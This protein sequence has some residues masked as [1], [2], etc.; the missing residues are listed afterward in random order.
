[1]ES[2]A[3]THELGVCSW[4]RMIDDPLECA[5]TVTDS[6]GLRVVQLALD[7]LVDHPETSGRW[8]RAFR[9]RGFTIASGM[10]APAGEDYT[11]IGSIRR[12]GGFRVEALWNGH[13]ERAKQLAELAHNAAIP[14][15]TMHAGSFVDD[16]GELCCEIVDRIRTIALVFR[17]ADIEV[18][19]ET[20]HEPAHAVL[21]LLDAL[22]VEGVGVNF[23]PANM[24]LYGSGDPIEALSELLPYVY[25]CHIKD[26]IP[27]ERRELWGTEVVVGTGRVDWLRFFGC[28]RRSQRPI[29]LMVE[30]EAGDQR[31]DDIRSAIRFVHT[32]VPERAR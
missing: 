13:L 22:A 26:A 8:L 27:S 2:I 3:H 16:K 4:S 31:V 5:A 21:A 11:S 20:G 15:V 7:P 28:L 30:R 19:F 6:L 14:L 17:D 32:H 1:M 23:D 29:G 12:T 10:M 25:Q 24:L 9:D 18:A